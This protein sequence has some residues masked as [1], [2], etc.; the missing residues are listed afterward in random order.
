MKEDWIKEL[1]VGDEVAISS[2]K[3]TF[4]KKISRI[5]K[6]MIIIG[7]GSRYNKETGIVVGPNIWNAN[8]WNKEYLTQVTVEIKKEIEHRGLE[9][10]YSFL[11]NKISPK[12]LSK[13]DLQ[14]VISVL[15]KYETKK[16]V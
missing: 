1:R 5:T 14:S 15:G 10:R 8:F 13:E 4:I 7:N 12:Q 2:S 11:V 9:S 6:T 3:V 16:E